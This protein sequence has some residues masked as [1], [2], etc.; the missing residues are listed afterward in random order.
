MKKYWHIVLKGMSL[1]L[2][3][4]L[5]AAGCDKTSR[6]P[7]KPELDTGVSELLFPM[8]GG[9]QTVSFETNRDWTAMVTIVK[10]SLSSTHLLPGKSYG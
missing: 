2:P 6:L 7:E 9:E 3:A 4:A 5:I 8:S 1:L 10:P